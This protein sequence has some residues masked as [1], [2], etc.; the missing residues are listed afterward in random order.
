[1]GL[2]QYISF[3]LSVVAL[4][5]IN[6]LTYKQNQHV[7]PPGQLTH[8]IQKTHLDNH[9]LELLVPEGLVHPSQILFLDQ[10][11]KNYVIVMSVMAQPFTYWNVIHLVCLGPF[12]LP[13]YD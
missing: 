11:P 7:Q 6:I 9:N 13:H 5:Y 12:V 3:G 1:M 10:R 4:I 2:K 8:T